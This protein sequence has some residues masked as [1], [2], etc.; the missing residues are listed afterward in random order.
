MGESGTPLGN[1]SSRSSSAYFSQLLF[2][3][4][5]PASQLSSRP[6]QVTSNLS[7]SLLS[8]SA[9]T[10]LA[11][12]AYARCSERRV[13]WLPRSGPQAGR[14][15]QL[16]RHG[17]CSLCIEAQSQT[18]PHRGVIWRIAQQGHRKKPNRKTWTIAA[19][20]TAVGSK[21]ICGP[22]RHHPSW[23]PGPASAA[24]AGC[25]ADRSLPML[26]APLASRLP[27]PSTG[28]V[29]GQARRNS[30]S[31]RTVALFLR[32]RGN[33][34]MGSC[35]VLCAC[36]AWIYGMSLRST[37]RSGVL[38]M[39][40]IILK[41]GSAGG[42]ALGRLRKSKSELEIRA[43]RLCVGMLLSILSSQGGQSYIYLR[44]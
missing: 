40:S 1:P 32:R 17:R 33:V 8:E 7:D 3:K 27:V 30:S 42:R 20:A 9:L 34:T 31:A 10:N 19:P 15:N 26:Q 14:S 21:S 23:D 18:F 28:I 43:W 35:S 39:N 36:S 37:K 5:V 44:S 38:S 2:H 11:T 24:S 29:W 4:D 41:S 16:F 13:I 6:R 12:K 22:R 25:T